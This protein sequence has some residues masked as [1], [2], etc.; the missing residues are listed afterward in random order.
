MS[1]KR[2]IGP[3]DGRIP[4]RTFFATPLSSCHP[5]V[6]TRLCDQIT[7]ACSKASRSQ[8]THSL[9]N[10]LFEDREHPCW[11][12]EA[13]RRGTAFHLRPPLLVC[14]GALNGSVNGPMAASQAVSDCTLCLTT[15]V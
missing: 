8:A 5:C 13:E 3:I 14:G 15:T 12:A 10:H 6:R 2:R 7:K 9:R 11:N 4:P 1:V